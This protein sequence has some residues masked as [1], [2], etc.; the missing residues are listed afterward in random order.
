M[1]K[2]I[3]K[4]LLLNYSFGHNVWKLIS[5]GLLSPWVL[6]TFHCPFREFDL[7]PYSSQT[8]PGIQQAYAKS[9]I[10]HLVST[11]DGADVTESAQN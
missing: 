11:L 1:L 8:F 2:R 3:P 6:V 5:S 4:T 10:I 7:S 9:S